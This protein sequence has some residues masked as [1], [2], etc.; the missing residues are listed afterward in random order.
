M[1]TISMMD[2]AMQ[3]ARSCTFSLRQIFVM[4]PRWQTLR[5]SSFSNFYLHPV[6]ENNNGDHDFF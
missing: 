4:A 1:T 6:V 5:G 3:I 2:E